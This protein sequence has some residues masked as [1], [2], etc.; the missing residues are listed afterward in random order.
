VWALAVGQAVDVYRRTNWCDDELAA[1][2]SCPVNADRSSSSSCLGWGGGA[3]LLGGHDRARRYRDRACRLS[4][5]AVSGAPP[6]SRWRGAV[7]IY[8]H[9]A[10]T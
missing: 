9:N 10:L 7:D 2:G 1:R 8:R 5:L 6:P 4:A 3:A